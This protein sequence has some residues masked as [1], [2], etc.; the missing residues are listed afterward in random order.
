MWHCVWV[1]DRSLGPFFSL[2][3]CLG[4]WW[5][6]KNGLVSQ[7]RGSGGKFWEEGNDGVCVFCGGEGGKSVPRNKTGAADRE[8]KKEK[9][10]P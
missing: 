2:C 6:G 9:G 8:R 3:V 5:G 10:F 7:I 4:A 1:S